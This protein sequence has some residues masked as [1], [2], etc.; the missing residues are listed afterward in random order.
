MLVSCSGCKGRFRISAERVPASGARA[1]CT[2][3]G[4][5]LLIPPQETS[6]EP[7]LPPPLPP[8]L[9]PEPAAATMTGAGFGEIDLAD[10]PGPGDAPPDSPWDAIEQPASSGVDWNDALLDVGEESPQ[11]PWDALDEESARSPEEAP[12]PALP[13]DDPFDALFDEAAEWSNAEE[14]SRAAAAAIPAASGEG[15]APPEPPV[16]AAQDMPEPHP[17]SPPQ[18]GA[19]SRRIRQSRRAS[20]EGPISRAL[21]TSLV[22]GALIVG[23]LAGMGRDPLHLARYFEGSEGRSPVELHARDLTAG[24]FRSPEGR[25]LLYLRGSVHGRRP[26]PEGSSVFVAGELHE[27]HGSTIARSA[28]WAGVM[29]SPQELAAVRDDGSWES[30]SRRLASEVAKAVPSD[31]EVPFLLVFPS[32]RVP[33]GPL[34]VRVVATVE[35]P[36]TE[37]APAGVVAEE[38]G[39]AEPSAPAR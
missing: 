25:E 4:T 38:L 18:G 36:P 8:P 37:E 1:R 35:A 9:P 14:A 34:Q 20:R 22:M 32:A 12:A 21:W 26:S 11:R 7:R 29:P 10:G 15:D 24:I 23:A 3:C 31:G 27:V 16:E 6:A 28:S 30:L 13:A 19:G 33:R 5:I 17:A 39:G 2:R